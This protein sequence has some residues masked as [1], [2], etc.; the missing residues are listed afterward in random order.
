MALTACG[1]P[2]RRQCG[3]LRYVLLLQQSGTT[4]RTRRPTPPIHMTKRPAPKPTQHLNRGHVR[5]AKAATSGSSADCH[6]PFRE[7]HDHGG[8][9]REVE[10]GSFCS[11]RRFAAMRL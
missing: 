8:A 4:W 7:V 5:T 2:Q 10:D 1:V 9:S 6:R 3:H 11:Q